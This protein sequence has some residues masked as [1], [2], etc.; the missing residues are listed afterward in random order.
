MYPFL[1]Y[2]E[3]TDFFLTNRKKQWENRIIHNILK[4]KCRIFHRKFLSTFSKWTRKYQ[5]KT[6][7]SFWDILKKTTFSQKSYVGP[8]MQVGSSSGTPLLEWGRL[9]IGEQNTFFPNI[10]VHSIF[11]TKSFWVPTDCF[12]LWR[13]SIFYGCSL[14]LSQDCTNYGYILVGYYYAIS[15]CDGTSINGLS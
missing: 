6:F 1:I 9:H 3:N 10:W 15:D 2:F 14:A 12:T 8:S 5:E 13:L 11:I 7:T 4:K